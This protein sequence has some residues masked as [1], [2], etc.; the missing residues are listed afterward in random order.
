MNTDNF[1]N[2]LAYIGETE[3]PT[4][5]HR[6]CY[7][8]MIGALLGRNITM[9]FGHSII[10]PNM[11]VM[12]L[13]LAGARKSSAIK[14]VKRLIKLLGYDK[15][16][17]DKSTKEKFLMDLAGHEDANISSKISSNKILDINLWG[18]Q[19]SITESEPAESY[20]V[21][22]EW[23]EF[24]SLGNIEFYSMLGNFWDWHEPDSY[25]ESKVKNSKSIAIYQPTISILGGNTPTNFNAAFPPD[26]IGQGFFSR[27]LLISGSKTGKRITIPVGGDSSATENMLKYLRELQSTCR[28]TVEVA[29]GSTEYKLL[30]KIYRQESSNISDTR[31]DSYNNRRL[32]HLIKLTLNIM[33]SRL[34]IT[35]SESDILLANTLLTRAE[36][37]MPSALGEFGRSRT[38]S[39][40]NKLMEALSNTSKPL[41]LQELWVSISHDMDK[42]QQLGEVLANLRAADKLLA[43]PLGAGK[44]TGFMAKRKVLNTDSTD[45]LDYSL[46]TEDERE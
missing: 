3:S 38:S 34:S 41:T 28:G 19:N 15:L 10:A 22:D 5:Y 17:A 39:V 1:H 13:G 29:R 45:T 37:N 23:N 21:A 32:T 24:T 42:Q 20:I 46:L 30:D 27:L 8:S 36:H 35:I 40:A 31:F 7:L 33:A 18:E 2:Y 9:P 44:G 25:Y 14:P 43:V 6:W 11:Y 4:V 16:A 26:I 12:L